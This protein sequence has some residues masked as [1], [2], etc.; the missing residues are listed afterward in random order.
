MSI[1]RKFT[2][3]LT[4][5]VL[6]LLAKPATTF[7][8]SVN[9]RTNLDAAKIE[10]AQSG[11]LVLLHFWSPSCGPCRMLDRN[12][13]SQPQIGDFLEQ[14]FVPVK[15]NAD[16][17]PALAG[18]YRIDRVPTDIVLSTQG[19]V[20]ASLSCPGQP[21]AYAGQLNNVSQHYRQVMARPNAPAE[22]SVQSAYAG[23]EVGSYNAPQVP[24]GTAAQAQPATVTP[25]MATTNPY[26]VQPPTQNQYGST[27]QASATTTASNPQNFQNPYAPVAPP[28]AAKPTQAQL[29][30][31]SPPLGFEGYCPVTLKLARKW[32]AGNPQF[33]AVHR[34]RTFLFTGD[35]ERQQFLANPDAYSPVFS[36]MDAVLILDQQQA[37]EGSRKFGYEY[38]GA[39]Y[40]FS[41]KETMTH[42][43]S[44][45]DRYSAQVRQAMNRLD[46]N[47]GG[48]IRR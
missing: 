38:R 22:S 6:S 24:G 42:F 8:E 15:V 12:V 20:V 35:A 28:A 31:G 16:L 48:T 45:P 13:F 18:Q 39:F 5:V 44:N 43:A 17:S 40:L 41:S 36:G 21:E 23:L 29:P 10:A 4:T 37:V 30:A 3:V 9:W 11:K 1:R 2:L 34:G 27:V 25:A 7:A 19:S 32:V 46:S 14:H 33:G 47:L 26:T